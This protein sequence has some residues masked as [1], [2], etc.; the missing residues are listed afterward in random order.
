[1]LWSSPVESLGTLQ[2]LDQRKSR[3]RI[4]K[5]YVMT[6]S[7]VGLCLLVR[8]VK[9]LLEK[10]KNVYREKLTVRVVRRHY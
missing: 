9:V 6:R 4:K 7:G 1:M 3:Y 2:K 8:H 5:E 10:N